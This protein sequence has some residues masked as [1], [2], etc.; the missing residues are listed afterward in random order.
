MHRL[1]VEFYQ[2]AGA[3]MVQF[4]QHGSLDGLWFWDIE[5]PE[6]EWYSP[7]FCR[8]L[9]YEPDEVPCLSSWWQ[10]RIFA[11]DKEIALANFE[12]HIQD[13]NHDYYQVVRYHHRDGST[14]WVRCRGIAIRENGKPIRLL[15]AHIDLT[16]LKETQEKLERLTFTDPLTELLNRR[17]LE[18]VL[19][20]WLGRADREKGRVYAAV[21]D[22]DDFKQVNE[23][24][25]HAGGDTLLSAIASRFRDTLRPSDAC[26]RIGGDEFCVLYPTVDDRLPAQAA[27]HRMMASLEEPFR[28]GP[29]SLVVTFSA[30]LVRVH[31]DTIKSILRD[32]RE[33]LQDA[34]RY[35]KSTIVERPSKAP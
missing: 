15:G 23:K 26:G 3:E 7:E 28:L 33:A 8:L 4:L 19:R 14:V 2:R 11:E 32:A 16:E 30:A 21:I 5:N 10:E 9:G 22:L 12:R 35:G 27:L 6:E 1:E 31:T 13:P 24:H 25:G 20:R 18:E 29:H 34:K 17:G